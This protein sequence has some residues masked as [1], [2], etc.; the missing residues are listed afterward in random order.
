MSGHSYKCPGDEA[1][2][3]GLSTGEIPSFGEDF[4]CCKNTDNSQI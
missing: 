1:E 3:P 2:S 4:E